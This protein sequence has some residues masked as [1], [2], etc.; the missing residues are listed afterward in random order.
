MCVWNGKG[1]AK[2]VNNRETEEQQ[3]QML[4]NQGNKV[5]KMM[6]ATE[7]Q[8]EVLPFSR[9][10]EKGR[11][12]QLQTQDERLRKPMITTVPQAKICAQGLSFVLKQKVLPSKPRP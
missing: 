3:Q 11:E 8:V 1:M 6:G 2:F 4:N 10:W 7:I 9:D 5:Y 12:M